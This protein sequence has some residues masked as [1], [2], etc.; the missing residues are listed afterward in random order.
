MKEPP[1]VSVIIPAYKAEKY[2]P[3][4]LESVLNQT[5]TN[6]EIIVV[7]DG[8]PNSLEPVVAPYMEKDNRIRFYRKKNG[9]VSSARN[10][11]FEKSQGEFVSFLDAD[12]VW[13][14]KNLDKKIKALS[15]APSEF[16]YVH[17]KIEVI[18]ANSKPTGQIKS[19]KGGEILTEL[20]LWEEDT[21]VARCANLVYRREV[22]EKIGLF[23]EN[24]STAADQE[25]TFRLAKHYKGIFIPE[26]LLYYRIHDNN[27]HSNVPLHEKDHILAY[28]LAEKNN[29][30]PSSKIKRKAF[31]NLYLILAGSW[32]KNAG[33]KKRGLL[34]LWKAF[35]QDP[36][37]FFN[38][39]LK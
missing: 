28:K 3:E 23:N 34:F 25:L 14:P 7:D 29:L 36:V 30:F 37:N 20:L 31:S 39:I 21:I 6:L 2:L 15:E 8:S 32:W 4:T 12:D 10:F 16:G 26:V 9:G 27:M 33:N 11:G 5:Y 22:L 35:L 17:S 13:M 24:L 18:D 38:K 1:L 19:G